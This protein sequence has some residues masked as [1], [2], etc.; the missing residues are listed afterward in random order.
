MQSVRPAALEER[1]ELRAGPGD[2]LLAVGDLRL[3]RRREASDVAADQ[4]PA[5]AVL[6]RSVEFVVDVPH[7]LGGQRPS[8]G[9]VLAAALEELRV[10]G[11]EGGWLETL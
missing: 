6:Q 7:R 8:G 4:L 3:R 2:L 1:R 9:L 10:Q 5:H 11:V